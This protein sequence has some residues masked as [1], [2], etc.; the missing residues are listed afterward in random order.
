MYSS[1]RLSKLEEKIRKERELRGYSSSAKPISQVEAEWSL[2]REKLQPLCLWLVK[3][4]NCAE[5]GTVLIS[6][7]GQALDGYSELANYRSVIEEMGKLFEEKGV[8]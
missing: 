5:D 7:Q 4:F 3:I 8:K 6:N 2:M 1:F